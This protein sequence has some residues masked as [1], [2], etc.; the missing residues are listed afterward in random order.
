MLQGALRRAGSSLIRP[1]TA[2][3]NGAKAL[4]KADDWEGAAA[5]QAVQEVEAK[6]SADAKEKADE[7]KTKVTEKATEE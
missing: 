1:A 2:K 4:M 5:S 6:H 7:A 3:L